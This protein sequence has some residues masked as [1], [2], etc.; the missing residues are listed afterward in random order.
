MA[1]NI[2]KK[3]AYDVK[4]ASNPSRAIYK[5][6]FPTRTITAKIMRKVKRYS[7]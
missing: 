2:S 1:E 7:M 3:T 4:E 6:P 5:T